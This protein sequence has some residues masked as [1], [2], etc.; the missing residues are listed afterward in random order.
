LNDDISMDEINKMMQEMTGRKKLNP[1]V[2]VDEDGYTYCDEHRLEHCDI[3]CMS[4]TLPNKFRK[5]ELKTG[6]SIEEDDEAFE[7]ISKK[8]SV[9]SGHETMSLLSAS[10]GK[11]IRSAEA[12]VYNKQMNK[13]CQHCGKTV[14]KSLRCSKCKITV[15]CSKECQRVAWKQHKSECV[16]VSQQTYMMG[17]VQV[18]PPDDPRWANPTAA[19]LEEARR[20]IASGLTAS[21]VLKTNPMLSGWMLPFE[22]GSMDIEEEIAKKKKKEAIKSEVN[23]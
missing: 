11:P 18:P 20:A 19:D 8:H 12:L 17:N 15:Y 5:N 22:L 16:P 21:E 2:Y 13:T 9:K 7:K 1:K 3:C 23:H 6:R 14:V 10:Q 4:F